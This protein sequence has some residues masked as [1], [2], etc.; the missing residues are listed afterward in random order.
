MT[1]ELAGLRGQRLLVTGGAGVIAR[2]IIEQLSNLGADVLSVD[3]LPLAML[4]PRGVTHVRGDLAEME[5]EPLV[6]FRPDHVVHLAA[7]FERAAE[8]PEFWESNWHDNVVVTHRL[9][10]LAERVPALR[11]FV[12][13][14]SYLVYEPA[15]YLFSAPASAPVALNEAS[16]LGPRNL[17]GAAKLYGEAEARFIRDVR[18]SE[19]RVVLPRIYR[20]YGRGSRD[21]VSRWVRAALL[22][23]RVD[24]YHPENL[25][26][27]VYSGDVA[28]GILRLALSPEAAGPVNLASG[29]SRPV[30]DVIAGI[31]RATGRSLRRRQVAVD[32]PYEAS[33]ADVGRLREL[34][35]WIPGTELSAGIERVVAFERSAGTR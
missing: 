10:E 25:F 31:E 18:G 6:A 26:D 13:A 11:T 3:R 24:V 9:A 22:G 16:R 32:E 33:Q 8:T 35:G 14:S 21:V 2:E 1:S 30:G 27:Y 34:T 17:C 19:A 20:V 5:L 23:D 15:Q 7:T 4:P 29:R 12:Y 28:E